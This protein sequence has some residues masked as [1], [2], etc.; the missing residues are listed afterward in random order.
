MFRLVILLSALLTATNWQP[1]LATTELTQ[2][3]LVHLSSIDNVVCPNPNSF[4]ST[5]TLARVLSEKDSSA[6]T[7]WSAQVSDS[8]FFRLLGGKSVS[9]SL[10]NGDLTTKDVDNS[11]TMGLKLTYGYLPNLEV[12]PHLLDWGEKFLYVPSLAFGIVANTRKENI[13]VVIDPYST[14]SQFYYCNSSCEVVLGP[15]GTCS[16]CFGFLPTS[17]GLSSDHLVLQTNYGGFLVKAKGFPIESLCGVGLVILSGRG[18]KNFTLFTHFNEALCV[19]EVISWASVSLGNASVLTR[20]VFSV[21]NN[22]D[23]AKVGTFSLDE[24]MND[25]FIISLEVE[26]TKKSDFVSLSLTTTIKPCGYGGTVFLALFAHNDSPHAL[27]IVNITKEGDDNSKSFQIKHVEGLML[28]PH[29]VTQAALVSYSLESHLPDID[30]SCKIF[31]HTNGFGNSRVEIPCRDIGYIFSIC[32]RNNSESSEGE[33]NVNV[34]SSSLDYNNSQGWIGAEAEEAMPMNG[35]SQATASDLSVLEN[36]EVIFPVIEVGHMSS[37]WITVKNPSQEPVLVQLILNSA[38]IIDECGPPE[39]HLQASSSNTLMSSNNSCVLARYGFSIDNN[40]VTEALISPL[41]VASLGPV[42]FRPGSPCRWKSSAL[43]RNNLSGTEWVSLSGVGGS[44][45]MVLLQEEDHEPIQSLDFK[46]N[47]LNSSFPG[48]SIGCSQALMKEVYAKNTGDLPLRVIRIGISGTGCVSDGFSVNFCKGFSLSPG[49]SQKI[50]VSYQTDFSL[51]TVHRDLELSLSNGILVIP[52]KATLPIHIL[53]LCK[54]TFLERLRIS[55]F[56]MLL[57][58]F[59]LF[60]FITQLRKPQAYD[61]YYYYYTPK[62]GKIRPSRNTI[63]AK[64]PVEQE[65][66]TVARDPQ[67]KSIEVGNSDTRE[68]Q[69]N[70]NNNLRV[71][72]GNE[73]GKRKRRK[74]KGSSGGGNKLFDVSSSSHSGNST[75]SPSSPAPRSPVSHSKP[76]CKREVVREAGASPKLGNDNPTLGTTQEKK[77]KVDT[78]PPPF[79]GGTPVSYVE[80]LVPP[81]RV[82]GSRFRGEEGEKVEEMKGWNEKFVTYDIWGDHLFGLHLT[83][84]N[85]LPMRAPVIHNNSDSFFAR[86]PQILM[87]NY[88]Q[89]KVGDLLK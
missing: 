46:M 11:D 26:S 49:E 32:V 3:V 84:D 15:G 54:K 88:S 78:S 66:G 45:F 1:C 38:E 65:K 72:V 7:Q 29:T 70:G 69:Q 67:K 43:I 83:K 81:L 4:C 40:A 34:R 64:A 24:W 80:T 9:C 61:Y 31:V 36:P 85:T 53:S 55:L 17:L 52:M 75:P 47:S 19:E 74:K 13:L 2:E 77:P 59:L 57:V 22:D 14:N 39:M 82:P 50:V 76:I 56:R 71:K 73:M 33:E 68:M 5:S 28:S 48:K 86:G 60:L 21:N 63:V 8:G 42:W 23:D 58:A 41:E 79:D 89:Q 87:T 37:E 30:V 62:S 10:N 6:P 27:R 25:T 51:A 16:I 35:R 12:R 18:S 44:V 20:K